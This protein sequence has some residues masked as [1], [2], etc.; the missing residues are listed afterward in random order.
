MSKS[1][2]SIINIET[3]DLSEFPEIPELPNQNEVF[4][5]FLKNVANKI[6]IFQFSN[7]KKEK[8]EIEIIKL[9]S[10]NGKWYSGRYIGEV[11]FHFGKNI[12]SIKIKPRFG[13]LNFYNM[14]EE[15]FNFKFTNSKSSK[16]ESE[17]QF[18]IRKFISFLWLHTISKSNKH[19]LPKKN[20]WKLYIGT[21]VKGR[22]DIRSS[23]NLIP[24]GKLKSIYREKLL[25]QEILRI[26]RKAYQILIKNYGL[27]DNY[28]TENAK[29][30]VENIL[31]LTNNSLINEHDY[32]R[33]KYNDIYISFKPAVDLSWKIIKHKNLGI[34][35]KDEAKEDF[36]ILVDM[37]EIWELYLKSILKK[38]LSKIG[39]QIVPNVFR[40]YSK[41]LFFTT[42]IPDIVFQKNDNIIIFDAKYK[43]MEFG[44]KDFDQSDF[45]QVHTYINYLQQFHNVRLGGL[46]YPISKDIDTITLDNLRANTLY[47]SEK[48][49]TKYIIDGINMSKVNDESIDKNLF[50]SE[51]NKFTNRINSLITS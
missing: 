26:L 11:K 35:N 4:S 13:S 39:W 46:L 38:S 47:S 19:G 24:F 1:K 18:L 33:I 45:F 42:I 34:L 40:V 51:T 21:K 36:G 31:N 49:E 16:I 41:K 3:T 22:I 7:N 10:S 37:A 48:G 28:I 15:V 29:E 17:F 9:N 32:K 23:V 20:E 12:Y 25:N 2:N 27:K 14:L 44:H 8:E 5:Y 6:S 50:L 30:V 43:K